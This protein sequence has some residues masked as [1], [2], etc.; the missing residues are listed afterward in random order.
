MKIFVGKVLYICLYKVNGKNWRVQGEFETKYIA[1]EH[2][3]N[4]TKGIQKQTTNHKE[5]WTPKEKE[6]FNKG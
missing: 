1:N 4:T 3:K 5:Y 2:Q 6:E